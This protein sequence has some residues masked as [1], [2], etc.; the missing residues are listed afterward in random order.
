MLSDF[1]PYLGK[2]CHAKHAASR[3]T[4]T[5][6]MPLSVSSKSAEQYTAEI[7]YTMHTTSCSDLSFSSPIAYS[8]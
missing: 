1:F 2:P 3:L 6:R 4:P 7:A 5:L 8:A